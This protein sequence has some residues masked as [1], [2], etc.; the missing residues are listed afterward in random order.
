MNRKGFTLVEL[1]VMLVVLTI[2]IGITVPNIAGIIKDNK[3]SMLL[4][5]ANRM[6]DSARVKTTLEENMLDLESD[7]DCAIFRL[8]YLDKNNNYKK[9]PN[10]GIY[11]MNESFVIVNLKVDSKGDG[12]K[13][14]TYDYFVRLIEKKET[15]IYGI[16][17]APA[18]EIEKRKKSIFKTQPELLNITSDIN[19]KI[20]DDNAFNIKE[21][22]LDSSSE[23]TCAIYKKDLK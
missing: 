6:L 10:D 16:N 8:S 11:D 13:E 21:K 1:L 3:N 15:K 5:D 9:G 18:S 22:I 2:L 4:D 23:I 7:R 19:L 12:T 14:Y 17:M 20:N